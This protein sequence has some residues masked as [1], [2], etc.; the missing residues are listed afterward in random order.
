[1]SHFITLF[2]QHSYIIL[3]LGILLELLAFPISGEVLMSYAGYFVFL[4]KMNYMLALL[5]VFC[6]GGIGI[7]STYWIGHAGGYK[8]IEKYGHY[9]HLGPERYQKVASW[10]ERIG[11]KLLIFAYFIPG[12]RH[13]TG[14]VSGISRMPFRKFMIPAYAGSFLWGFCFITLGKILGPRYEEF[15]QAA[16]KYLVVFLIAFA[17]IIILF[18]AYRFYKE[19]I[20]R[21][22]L[23]WVKKLTLRF[24]TIRAAE[25]FLIFLTLG[26]IGLVILMFGL[27]QD[28]LYSEFTRF[29]EIT[30]YVIRKNVNANLLERFLPFQHPATFSIIMAMTSII[31]WRNNRNRALEYFLLGAA[32]LGAIPYLNLIRKIFDYLRWLGGAGTFRSVN[33]PDET[34]LITIVIYGTCLYLLLRHSKNNFL[35]LSVTFIG[36]LLLVGLALANIAISHV[37]PSDMTGGYIYGAVWMFFLFLLIE[38]LRFVLDKQDM[39]NA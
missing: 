10:F 27:G 24:R 26:L 15:H 18:L 25:V 19:P 35:H 38:M 6:A 23:G 9:I 3:F 11:S 1:M 20:Q 36:L 17:A 30:E 33:F 2:E 14:Y 7:T 39:G 12:I 13:F 29:N 16:S 32:V 4:G 37:L 5:T 34:A 21:F 31:I 28:Y 22:L 8:L